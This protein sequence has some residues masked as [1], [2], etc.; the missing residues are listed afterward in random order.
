MPRIS[1]FI[2]TV[3]VARR[4]VQRTEP[5][6][7]IPRAEI[8][9]RTDLSRQS[10]RTSCGAKTSRCFAELGERSPSLSV[11]VSLGGYVS[12]MAL[13]EPLAAVEKASE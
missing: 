1:R 10:T 11:V 12:P 4:H 3:V 8:T 13:G 9:L 6:P 7:A 5:H 2:Q